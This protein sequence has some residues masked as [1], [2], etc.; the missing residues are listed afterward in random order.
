MSSPEKCFSDFGA[1]ESMISE[2]ISNYLNFQNSPAEIRSILDGKTPKGK[3][4]KIL[5]YIKNF[6]KVNLYRME[7]FLKI[8]RSR[9]LNFFRGKTNI[10][11]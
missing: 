11:C 6:G 3:M 8:G 7:K 2:K 1:D 5:G 4:K 9:I 10:R